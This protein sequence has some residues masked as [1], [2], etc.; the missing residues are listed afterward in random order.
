[1]QHVTQ[2]VGGDPDLAADFG[3]PAGA[4]AH[5]ARP[6]TAPQRATNRAAALAA[7]PVLQLDD[8]AI[9]GGAGDQVER[10]GARDA[11]E[12][13]GALARNVGEHAQPE[14]VDQVELH[15]RPPKA[16]AAPG[17]DVTVA[18]A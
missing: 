15:E 11:V 6:A 2:P 16:D 9:R 13:P 10:V 18:A 12:Q 3:A 4:R 1:M 7:P 14:L 17:G 5:A 8:P